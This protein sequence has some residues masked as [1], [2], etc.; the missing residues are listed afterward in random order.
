M[1][2]DSSTVAGGNLTFKEITT[3]DGIKVKGG[4][5]VK[6]DAILNNGLCDVKETVYLK[7]VKG[8]QGLYYIDEMTIR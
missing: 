2:C 7:I 4:Y 5:K 8:E 6:A 3:F 1:R